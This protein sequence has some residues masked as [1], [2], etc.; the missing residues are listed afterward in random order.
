MRFEGADGRLEEAGDRATLD[1]YRALA[2]RIDPKTRGLVRFAAAF[3][4]VAKKDH[5]GSYGA[6]VFEKLAMTKISD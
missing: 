6:T 4:M 5:K 1:A 3:A 2:K